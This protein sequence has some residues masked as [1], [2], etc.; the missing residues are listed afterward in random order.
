MLELSAVVKKMS[1]Q[2]IRIFPVE[3]TTSINA[4]VFDRIS[5]GAVSGLV[6]RLYD[7][8]IKVTVSN[9]GTLAET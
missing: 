2:F 7:I 9:P 6:H 3:R 8:N 4:S 5:V 1:L